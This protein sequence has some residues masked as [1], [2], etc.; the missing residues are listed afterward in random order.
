[1]PGDTPNTGKL[2]WEFG[3]EFS[4]VSTWQALSVKFTSDADKEA[5]SQF[6]QF[7][8]YGVTIFSL[9]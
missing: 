9:D 3:I 7:F 8:F 2:I 4:W 6:N 1:M 5:V